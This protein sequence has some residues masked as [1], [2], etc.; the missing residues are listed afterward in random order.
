MDVVK[1]YWNQTLGGL[2]DSNSMARAS[3]ANGGA[4]SGDASSYDQYFHGQDI[5]LDDRCWTDLKSLGE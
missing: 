3:E 4:Q 1:A 5:A 2:N